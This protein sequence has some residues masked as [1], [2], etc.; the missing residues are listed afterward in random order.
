[1][2]HPDRA[3]G[4][5]LGLACGDAL[6]AAVEGFTREQILEQRGGEL[7]EMVG[8]G[9]HDLPAGGVT[10]DTEMTIALAEALIE[11]GGYDEQVAL[12]RYVA[13]AQGSP[14]GIGLNTRY[15]LDAAA[16]GEDPR[17]A[18]ERYHRERAGRGAGNGSLMRAAPLALR[19]A[20]EPAELARV[21]E[22]DSRLTHFDDRAARA[23]VQ[24]TAL[25]AGL[26]RGEQPD[27]PVAPDRA[28]AARRAAGL[29]AFVEA[30]LLV[31]VTALHT[32]S[33]FEEG[34][35]WAVNLGG[36]TDTNAAVAGALLG[37][38]HGAAAIPERWQRALAVAGE[39]EDLARSLIDGRPPREGA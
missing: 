20:H 37:A 7:R 9:P 13:W 35:V 36:D 34:V 29:G 26:L 15:V 10:D 27:L 23:C 21:A 14:T 1:M 12:R 28:E 8:G 4:A 11:A 22:A 38:C 33:D 25:L 5:L 18:A 30:T 19:Y 24:F 6:G 32:A 39:L 31:A 17:A 2:T 3:L 16:A